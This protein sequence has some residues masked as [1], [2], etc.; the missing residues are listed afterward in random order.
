ME[1]G[2]FYSIV[3][4]QASHATRNFDANHP[5]ILLMKG[6]ALAPICQAASSPEEMVWRAGILASD[7]PKFAGPEAQAYAAKL[8]SL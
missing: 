1:S 5:A 3:S 8:L 2:R 4:A 7:N 6:A